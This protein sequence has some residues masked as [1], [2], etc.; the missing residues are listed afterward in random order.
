[1]IPRAVRPRYSNNGDYTQLYHCTRSDR[2][3]TLQVYRQAVQSNSP[4]LTCSLAG[5]TVVVNLLSDGQNTCFSH[6]LNPM[7]VRELSLA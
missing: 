4:L 7:Y 2:R 6:H 1:M 3:A 5:I